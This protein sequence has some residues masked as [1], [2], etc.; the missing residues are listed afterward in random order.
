VSAG[1]SD[2]QISNGT[3]K[4]SV[5]S[6]VESDVSLEGEASSPLYRRVLVI[7]VS[8]LCGV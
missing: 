4:E 7:T 3:E 6:V 2:A 1:T 8:G 5:R